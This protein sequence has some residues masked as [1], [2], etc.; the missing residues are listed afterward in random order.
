MRKI[1]LSND[2]GFIAPG[3]KLLRD[4]LKTV[5]EELLTVTPD[6]DKSATSNSLTLGN[7]L[8]LTKRDENFYSINGTPADSVHVGLTVLCKNSLPDLVVSGINSGPNMGDDVIYSGTVA[9][10]MEGRHLRL[11]AIAVSMDSFDPQHY[12]SGVQAVLSLL[13]ILPNFPVS[14]EENV[15]TILNMN[16]P[17]LPWNEIKGFKATRLG[18]RHKSQNVIEE[19]DPRGRDIYWIGPAGDIADA[20]EGTDFFATAAA[21]VS[22]TPLHIDLT[23]YAV[24]ESTSDWLSQSRMDTN[25][26]PKSGEVS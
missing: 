16:V 9:A 11:P 8:R 12:K 5:T 26:S 24:L 19:Q 14:K 25:F 1:L 23:Q 7:P 4:G 22:V 13:D 21:Y 6:R 17:D 3:V 18:K 20:Q 10:A 2:D 15:A